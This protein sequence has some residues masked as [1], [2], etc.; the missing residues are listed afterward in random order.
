MTSEMKAM[1]EG[2]SGYGS[3]SVEPSPVN[4]MMASFASDFRDHVDINLGVGYVNES[5]IPRDLIREALDAVLSLPEKYRVPFNYG[6]PLGSP[7]LLE[8]IRSFYV[9]QRIGG[10][11]EEILND[12]EI[13]IGANGATGILESLAD[14]L[15]PGIV[16]TSDPMYYIYC[17]LLERKGFRVVT[18]PEDDHGI[19]MDLLEERLRAMGSERREISFFYIVTV[20]NPTSSIL[21]NDR[22]MRL[23]E[24]VS[25]V[26]REL[27]RKVP[28]IMD[29]A[30]ELLVHDPHVPPLR[31]G[32][33]NDELGVVY[34]VGT[35][36]KVFA[37]ALRIGYLIGA[38]G[39]LVQALTQ[40]TSD[41]GFSAPLINQ[42]LTSY[43]LDH[44]IVGQAARVNKGYREKAALIREGIERLL[45]PYLE[46]YC[47]GKAG[48]YFYLTFKD[49]E[50]TENSLFF[51]FLCRNT[52]R[53]EIDGV[54]EQKPRVV[55][56]PGEF[57]VHPKG[58]MVEAGKRQLRIS[59]GFEETQR[60][61]RALEY[62]RE[63][64]DYAS[65]V[66]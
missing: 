27:E 15:R 26:S 10:L 36:S 46:G 34:E 61:I 42:E 8:S 66:G 23:L 53:S 33:I 57:C 52:G 48:F 12:K 60:I 29:K 3:L 35:L 14:I 28:L 32:L 54:P 5:T 45:S 11:T 37:P 40:K 2:F 59:Y 30:Y 21:A 20:N 41:T 56:I 22:R 50:T 13:R 47:G 9:R 64:L 55:Y 1:L 62:M 38:P 4:S 31:S 25:E 63:A 18:I 49:I 6:G 24:M 16:I 58:D 44:H 65:G 51:R 19:R 7:N 17:N 43:L 39:P